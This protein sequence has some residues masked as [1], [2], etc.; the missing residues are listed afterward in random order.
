VLQTRGES[1]ERSRLIEKLR[2]ILQRGIERRN[3]CRIIIHGAFPLRDSIIY[4]ILEIRHALLHILSMPF[5][6]VVRPHAKQT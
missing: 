1:P 2:D 4:G 6:P 3:F 5:I